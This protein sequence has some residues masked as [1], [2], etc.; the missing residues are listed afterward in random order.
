MTKVAVLGNT[1]M[2][3]H[4]VERVLAR[5][6]ELEVEGFGR[7]ALELKPRTLNQIGTKLTMLL[8]FDTQWIVN[9]MGATKPYFNDCADLS[10]P[11]YANAL[12][13][14]QLA[15]WAELMPHG[16]NV[17][18]ITTDCVY[19]GIIGK[20]NEQAPHSAQDMYGKSKSLGEP[21]NCMVLRTSI[22]GPETGGR[23][24]HF[25]SWVKS[26]DKIKEESKGFTNHMWNGVTTLELAY[27]ISDIICGYLY[28][29]GMFHVFGSDISKYEMVATI[30]DAYGLNINLATYETPYPI[31]RR[32]RTLKGLNDLV[33]PHTFGEMI[34]ELKEWEDVEYSHTY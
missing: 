29:A 20:Y 3:G 26:R 2:L 17:I 8:G 25:L 21:E 9:C 1:G 14:H 33:T 24:R 31:D 11:V 23:S 32:L 13:P 7:E 34:K 10:I 27:A 4:V 18:H 28:E 5:Q 22:I 15:K 19:D 30:A 12:F 6:M 16:P